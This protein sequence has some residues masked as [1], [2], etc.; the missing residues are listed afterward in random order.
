MMKRLSVVRDLAD[1]VG[2][3]NLERIEISAGSIIAIMKDG[4]RFF[5][6]PD[7]STTSALLYDGSYEEAEM[8]LMKSVIKEGWTVLD[9]GANFGWYASHFSKYVGEK[10]RVFAFEP[11]P[12]TFEELKK[13]IAF[14]HAENVT[15]I[16]R[17]LGEKE[18]KAYFF[19]PRQFRGSGGASRYNYFG[20]KVEVTVTTLDEIVKVHQIQHLDFIKADIEGGELG[21]LMGG[22]EALQRFHPHISLEV[23]EWHTERFGYGPAAV[24]DFLSGLGYRAFG[25]KGGGELIEKTTGSAFP[26]GIADTFYFKHSESPA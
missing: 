26:P 18:E 21:M 7:Q 22:K 11:I 2:R 16:N 20:D 3:K 25:I 14:N 4:T 23:Q 10:G 1:M 6:Q 5:V 12:A 9:V 13:N 8:A 24:F 17:A 19:L 15:V